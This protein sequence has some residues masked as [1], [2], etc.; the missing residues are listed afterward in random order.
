MFFAHAVMSYLVSYACTIF[1]ESP[2]I[3]LQKLIFE[4]SIKYLEQ[5]FSSEKSQ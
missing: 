5:D 2:F 1:F 3:N 4:G